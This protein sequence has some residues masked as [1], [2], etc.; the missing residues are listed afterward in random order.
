MAD[1]KKSSA[2]MP[3][4]TREAVV[5]AV[6]AAG[7]VATSPSNRRVASMDR[8]LAVQEALAGRRG[9]VADRKQLFE[10]SRRGRVDW[11][12]FGDY[13]ADVEVDVVG[14]ARRGARV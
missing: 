8:E 10:Q 9:P 13:A 14:H 6:R 12:G 2:Q 4:R 1:A 7:T 5:G 3:H 11:R